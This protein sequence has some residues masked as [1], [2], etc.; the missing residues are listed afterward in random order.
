[1][2]IKDGTAIDPVLVEDI[3]TNVV[4][5]DCKHMTLKDDPSRTIDVKVLVNSGGKVQTIT[6]LSASFKSYIGFTSGRDEIGGLGLLGRTISS[7]LDAGLVDLRTEK[8]A[9]VA[10]EV[11]DLVGKLF[12]DSRVFRKLVDN[13]AA[14]VNK[15]C[16]LK[17]GDFVSEEGSLRINAAIINIIGGLLQVQSVINSIRSLHDNVDVL[18]YALR[19]LV[20][21]VVC[22]HRY[23]PAY[24]KLP[25]ITSMLA[26]YDQAWALGEAM[27]DAEDG[28]CRS[29]SCL[30]IGS[31][32]SKSK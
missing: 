8:D 20:C 17:E 28:L 5:F 2:D 14:N 18:K 31:G 15:L 26:F 29:C 16:T 30:G 22:S 13:I 11:H 23:V 1:M 3:A 19:N 10:E 25:F 6:L 24:I 21:Y 12:S 27:A 32:S 4:L 7:R 9:C